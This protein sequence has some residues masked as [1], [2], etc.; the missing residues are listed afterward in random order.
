MSIN[1]IV[2]EILQGSKVSR[3]DAVAKALETMGV[4][5]RDDLR[6]FDWKALQ[7][8]GELTDMEVN[9]VMRYVKTS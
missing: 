6:Y 5:T 3:I 4:A 2:A 9:K 1:E 7:E 8:I